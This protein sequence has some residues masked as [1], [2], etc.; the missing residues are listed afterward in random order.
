[1]IGWT[2][3]VDRKSDL[4]PLD[5]TYDVVTTRDYLAGVIATGRLRKKL[6]NL[7]KSYSY[8]SVGYYSSLLAEAR[9][10]KILPAVSTML[11]LRRRGD[12]AYALAD[13][14]EHLNRALRRLAEP[15][16]A[17]FRLYICLGRCD[18][19]ALQRFARKLFDSFRVP[20]LEVS[21][22][23]VG[24]WYRIHRV[25]PLALTD[26][27][28][29]GTV[30][31]SQGL[32][33]FVRHTWRSPKTKQPPRWTLAVLRDAKESMPPSD[34]AAL[35]RLRRVAAT[36]GVAVEF[37]GKRDYDRLA[38][39]DALFIRETTN[40]DH[41]TYRFAQRARQERMPV[42]DDPDS[43]MRCSNKVFL[44]ELLRAQGIAVPRTLVMGGLKD[45]D[46]AARMLG[47]PM[48]L[49]SPD[50][51]FS[52]GV[53]KVSNREELEAVARALLEESDLILAQE[54]MF[55]AFDWRV[56][57]L[58]GEPLFVCQYMMARNHWQIVHHHADGQHDLGNFKTWPVEQA[59]A[60]VID[61][62]VRA[63]RLMGNG[64]YGV[65]IKQTATG[66][67]F[68]IEVND[69]PNLD[70][71]VE[72][73]ILKDEL[74]RRLLGWFVHRLERPAA[75]KASSAVGP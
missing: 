64:L 21:I 20:L 12:Y 67:V 66:E 15:I 43:I 65:D 16:K 44:A 11:E 1:M 50:G 60:P 68:V 42:I 40:I 23:Q 13:L 47:Y 34:S 24:E 56:G 39:Y 45:L 37:I 74:W 28:A 14:E 73:A 18:R 52:R 19:P 4:P 3:I 70:A 53:K 26:L 49:K 48:V 29:E 25:A 57:V 8:Q 72:D 36:M 41:H 46:R 10:Q 61:I 54:F 7:S 35:E 51:S 22:R 33:D 71:G 5:G 69:N 27:N 9:G 6:I 55:T 62:A 38:E 63:A 32:A 75:G 31:F 59:P 17:P 58:G 30:L 2:L